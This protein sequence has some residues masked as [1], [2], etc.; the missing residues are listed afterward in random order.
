M[1]EV[2]WMFVLQ[3]VVVGVWETTNN[4]KVIKCHSI[5][6]GRSTNLLSQQ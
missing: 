3:W 1:F 6:D 4:M 5:R 2:V